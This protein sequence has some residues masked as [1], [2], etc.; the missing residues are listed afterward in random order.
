MFDKR[1]K[2]LEEEVKKLRI[3]LDTEKEIRS[4]IVKKL[5]D[6]VLYNPWIEV[7]IDDLK[8]AL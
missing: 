3:E 5:G 8:K 1:I 4:L 7:F 6:I 2:R